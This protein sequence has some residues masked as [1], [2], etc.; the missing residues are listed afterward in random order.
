M[1][2]NVM[3]KMEGEQPKNRLL[4]GDIIVLAVSTDEGE[5]SLTQ[6]VHSM[7]M[8]DRVVRIDRAT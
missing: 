6:S 3:V 4:L 8:G 1:I 2:S 5:D 7:I